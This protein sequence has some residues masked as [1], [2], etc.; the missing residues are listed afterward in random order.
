MRLAFGFIIIGLAATTLGN[1]VL[2]I[3]PELNETIVYFFSA[4]FLLFSIFL[5]QGGK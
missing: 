3:Y 2:R 1:G 4:A 5:V